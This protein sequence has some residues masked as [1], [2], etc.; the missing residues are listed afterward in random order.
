MP[1]F[2]YLGEH[3]LWNVTAWLTCAREVERD[4]ELSELGL[5]AGREPWLDVHL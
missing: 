4:R 2:S 3:W 1:E 5:S